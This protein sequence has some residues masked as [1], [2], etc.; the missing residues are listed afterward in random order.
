MLVRVRLLQ[1][2]RAASIGGAS[3]RSWQTT[4]HAIVHVDLDHP[5]KWWRVHHHGGGASTVERVVLS[6]GRLIFD[7]D[8]LARQREKV[9]NFGGRLGLHAWAEGHE[10]AGASAELDPDLYFVGDV[11]YSLDGYIL[12]K[13]RGKSG[14]MGEETAFRYLVF[15][16]PEHGHTLAL[17]A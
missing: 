9:G 2:A 15:L 1:V 3:V 6:D 8:R 12:E 13:R 16:N 14:V 17:F 10:V 4:D 7:R 5:E 11:H